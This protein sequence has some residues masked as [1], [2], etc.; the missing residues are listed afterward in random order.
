MPSIG[1]LIDGLPEISQSKLVA[2]GY[3]IWV[4]WKGTLHNS[5]EKTLQEYGA[6][7]VA[8]DTDQALWF[9][10]TVEVFRAMARLQVWGRLN[11]MSVIFQIMPLTFLVGYDLE[12]SVS[13]SVELDRQNVVA[14][15]ELE[16]VIHPKLKENI[17]SVPGLSSEKIGGIDGLANVEWLR[18]N[19]DQGL[20]YETLRKWYFIIKP[21]GRMADKEAILGWRDFSGEILLLLQKLGLK[22]ISD[23]KEGAIFFPLD[24]FRLLL[25]F[26]TE[27]MT[28]IKQSKEDEE[29]KYW[30]IVMAAAPQDNLQFSTDLPKKVGLDWNRMTP[31]FPH[32]RF[33]DGFLLSE[34]FRV[35]EARYG[36]DQ[37]SLDSWCTLALKEGEEGFGYGTMQ[38]ALPNALMKAEGEECFYCGL[39]NH[40][41]KD[42]PTKK[43]DMPQPQIWNALAGTN[44]NDFSD[45]FAEIDVDVN[46]DNFSRAILELMKD[47]NDL[48]SVMTKAV[49]EINAPSQLRTMKVVW[50]SRS[51][52]WID[53]AK[54]LAPEEGEYVWDALKAIESGNLEKAEGLIK[55]AQQ[56]YPRS[57]Q[58]HSLWGFY[59]LERKD[60]N[61][62]LFQWQEA[63]RTSYTP[64][65]QAI[66]AYLQAR[67]MEIEGNLKDAIN[68]YKH[69]NT[70]DASWQEPVYR[71]AV[72]MVKMGFSGQAM[73]LFSNLISRDPHVFNRILIDP[74][75]DR[76]RVQLMNALWEHWAQAEEAVEAM[77]VKV[78]QL[79]E[80]ITKRFDENHS[81]FETANED[82]DRL[83]QLGTTSNFVAYY[84]L[85]R[86]GDRFQATLNNEVKRG[87]KRINSNLEYLS[88][89]VRQVQREAAWFPF[90]KLLLEF[91]KEFNFCVE[92]INWIKTQR[93]NEADN[94][95]KSLRFIEEIEDHIDSLQRRLVT[96][97]IVRDSTLFI[98]MLG[99]NFIWLEL[100][101]LGLLLVGLPSLIYF[102]RDVQGSY[103]IDLI[104][105]E[106][107][108]WEICKG[109]VIIISI[110]AVAFSAVKSAFSFDKRKRELFDQLDEEIRQVAPKRY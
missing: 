21:L 55:E 67:L 101:G 27:I 13:L 35:N 59:Y 69:A 54:Q 12:Y 6:L 87:I 24:N 4:A 79:S 68:A 7:C 33:M 62:A 20:D 51:K 36:T 22:Y 90:P 15:D 95:R 43:L 8:K 110:V 14:P 40:E 47:K 28:L 73:D 88:D 61:Q 99:R 26:C 29:K 74:E 37:M 106:S 39:K 85:L 94:F 76:G 17:Q 57:Y 34:W 109:L 10:N 92:K 56:Q 49:F 58:P 31:D 44:I 38:V 100:I 89:R 80:D 78:D 70:L 11:P 50:R 5:V 60:F 66:F 64:L 18:L 72:C 105:D 86:G 81:Y 42:C 48:K 16:V 96:L 3:G 30:P 9:C 46:D 41:S 65:Q 32:V 82:L 77:R 84:Q 71:Q 93:L 25:S 45:G 63:E 102:T 103:I 52:E 23:I 108:R 97:R 83:R 19:V 2:S 53:A 107:Q 104:N 75:L 98:L 91:N 1:K